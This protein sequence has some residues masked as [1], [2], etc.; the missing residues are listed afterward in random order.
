MLSDK[1][2]HALTRA[3]LIANTL[4]VKSLGVIETLLLIIMHQDFT[5]AH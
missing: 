4:H 2:V 1:S 5:G 3:T